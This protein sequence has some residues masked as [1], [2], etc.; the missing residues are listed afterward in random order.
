MQELNGEDMADQVSYEN[1]AGSVSAGPSAHHEL[2]H[3]TDSL[4]SA[5]STL[6]SHVQ[7]GMQGVKVRRFEI[8]TDVDD[9]YSLF[10]LAEN[11]HPT[12]ENVILQC[13]DCQVLSHMGCMEE[14]LKQCRP[15]LHES[16]CV[17]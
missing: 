5:A 4:E 13:R 16:C 10:C 14:W 17:W 9:I 2:T 11:G 8:R 15:E 1:R 12:D 7:P 6:I 3:L